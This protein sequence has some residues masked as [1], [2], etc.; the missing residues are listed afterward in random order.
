MK[1]MIQGHSTTKSSFPIFSGVS[2]S[3]FTLSIFNRWGELL[4]ET[5]D[6]NQGWNGYYRNAM[7]VQDVYVWKVRGEYANGERFTKVGDV[8]LIQ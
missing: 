5:H 6:V 1:C 4:F 7:C 8:T 2:S 3:N